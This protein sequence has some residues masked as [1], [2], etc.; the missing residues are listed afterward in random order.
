MAKNKRDD[1]FDFDELQGAL[2]DEDPEENILE[3]EDLEDSEEED[4]EDEGFE[5]EED[6]EDGDEEGDEEGDDDDEDEE[7]FK[8]IAKRQSLLIDK[9]IASMSEKK[10]KEEKEEEEEDED[11]EAYDFNQFISDDET[12]SNIV[13]NREDFNKFISTLVSNVRKDVLKQIPDIVDKTATRKMQSRELVANFNKENPDLV[14]YHRY[15]AIN[16]REVQAKNPNMSDADVLKRAA[17]LTRKDLKLVKTSKDTEG[18]RKKK[19]KVV[20]P[21]RP[22]RGSR[23]RGKD[24]RSGKEKEIADLLEQIND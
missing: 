8:A 20:T 2:E 15:V 10:G 5:D 6:D 21:G 24:T 3:D 23:N 22:N 16:A 13:E 19:K 7:D 9:L 17:V 12:F 4:L 18:E 14:P 1:N 11:D